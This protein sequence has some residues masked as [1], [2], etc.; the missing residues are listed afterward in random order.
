MALSQIAE[1]RYRAS[2]GSRGEEDHFLKINPLLL[3]LLLSIPTILDYVEH[4]SRS[5]NAAGCFV[6]HS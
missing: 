3:G 5:C 4:S 6:G 1:V 2:A